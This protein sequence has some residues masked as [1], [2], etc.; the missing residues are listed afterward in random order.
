MRAASRSSVCPAPYRRQPDN[1]KV[2]EFLKG[3]DAGKRVLRND[4]RL[5]LIFVTLGR[6]AAPYADRP[7]ALRV[8]GV[9]V[10]GTNLSQLANED[11]TR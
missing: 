9:P 2:A 10:N 5:V 1:A 4:F 7:C 6:C 3:M 8:V 11:G